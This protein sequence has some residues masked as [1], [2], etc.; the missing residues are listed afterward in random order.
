MYTMLKRHY[1]EKYRPCCPVCGR[2]VMGA[3]LHEAMR[4]GQSAASG[5]NYV[6]CACGYEGPRVP[7]EGFWVFV[8]KHGPAP[9]EGSPLA[10]WA[11]HSW[12]VRHGKKRFWS[13]LFGR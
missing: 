7:L 5:P 12:Q 3:M 10:A 9:F 11:Q 2:D 1:D 8:D 4:S 13:G 6:R